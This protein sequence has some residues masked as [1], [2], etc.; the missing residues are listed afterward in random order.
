M[1][2]CIHLRE[3]L[4]YVIDPIRH[5]RHGTVTGFVLGKQRIFSQRVQSWHYVDG[6]V[7][8]VSRVLIIHGN[9]T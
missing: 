8:A 1:K 7:I 9:T 6:L 3:R 2:V 4:G 5:F